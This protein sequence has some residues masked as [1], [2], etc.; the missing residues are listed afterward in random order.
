MRKTV[1]GI[2][3]LSISITVAL[4]VTVFWVWPAWN[5][6]SQTWYWASDAG[7]INPMYRNFNPHSAN[8]EFDLLSNTPMSFSFK[9]NEAA[10]HML[11]FGF[12]HWQY[13]I[14]WYL[15]PMHMSTGMEMV[16]Y[17][18]TIG[19]WS[20]MTMGMMTFIP[21]FGAMGSGGVGSMAKPFVATGQAM[22][23]TMDR[24]V[25]MPLDRLGA[26]FMVMSMDN[27]SLTLSLAN[28]CF[29]TSP[30]S[31]PGYP[32]AA[33]GAPTL[34]QWGVLAL[35]ILLASFSTFVIKRRIRPGRS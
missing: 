17:T 30:L 13:N 15:T 28:T 21:F 1:E 29:I 27:L 35:A 32:G 22:A 33:V 10:L 12:D 8:I 2:K 16:N 9:A 5:S 18:L 6:G 24:F 34:S 19:K 31:D 23:M 4:L 26:M 14:E 3:W 11:D 7:G 25:F 20:G